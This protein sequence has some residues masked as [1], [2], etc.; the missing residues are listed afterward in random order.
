MMWETSALSE[1]QECIISDFKI[2]APVDVQ[3]GA[4]LAFCV[5]LRHDAERQSE[6]PASSMA[7]SN[8]CAFVYVFLS[9]RG[10]RKLIASA[11]L[12]A[13][14]ASC[15]AYSSV[16]LASCLSNNHD[17]DLANLLYHQLGR[18][19]YDYLRAFRVISEVHENRGGVSLRAI[20]ADDKGSESHR[21][22]VCIL[23]LD[24]ILQFAIAHK[25][26]DSQYGPCRLPVSIQRMCILGQSR[27]PLRGE[28]GFDVWMCA[29]ERGDSVILEVGSEHIRLK[30]LQIKPRSDSCFLSDASKIELVAVPTPDR[31]S[32]Q[33]GHLSPALRVDEK[34]H[35]LSADV[36]E[37]RDQIQRC[38]AYPGH[39]LLVST[40]PGFSGFVRSLHRE[41][42]YEQVRGIHVLDASVGNER[43]PDA[44]I[45]RA[46]NF[47][48]ENGEVSCL[49]VRM[50]DA[51]GGPAL[52]GEELRPAH[53]CTFLS[54]HGCFY[55]R[56]PEHQE[57]F[58]IWKAIGRPHGTSN[59]KPSSTISVA[60]TFASLNF[61]DVMIGLGKLDQHEAIKGYGHDGGGFGLDFAGHYLLPQDA[62]G[63]GSSLR[64]T[65]VI[66]LG[67]NCMSSELH[68][69]PEYL[70]W[71]LDDEADLE[72]Y[73]TVPCAYAS[74]YYA[75]CVRGRLQP[76]CTVLVHCGTGG[77]GLAALHICR[78]RLSAPESQLFVTC[79]S[80]AKRNYLA[81]T[82]GIPIANI[83]DSRSC[84]F[85]E[86]IMERTNGKGVN[87][88]LNSLTGELLKATVSC[89]SFGGVLLELGK[90]DLEPSVMQQLR[91]GDKAIMMIDLDQIMAHKDSFEEVRRELSDG[92]G[93]GEVVPLER[94]VF[95]APA[96]TNKAFECMSSSERIGKVVLQ[97]SHNTLRAEVP[98]MA[99]TMPA[100][101]DAKADAIVI[102]GGLGGFGL[103]LA[104]WIASHFG[105]SCRIIL[106]GRRSPC[107]SE[108]TSALHH[109][110]E[111][112]GADVEVRAG[113]FSQYSEISS[114]LE[115]LREGS[116]PARLLGVFNAAASTEDVA[117]D[118]MSS[119]AWQAPFASKVE[120]TLNL[121]RAVD[122]PSFQ[123]IC[124]SLR[125]FVC[126]SSV[127]AGLG[128]AYQT[129]Y[130]CANAAMERFVLDRNALGK[131][132]L[133]I[134]LGLIPHVGLAMSVHNAA[135][136]DHLRPISLLSALTQLE[137]LVASNAQ[138]L[139]A[140]Y[141]VG[142][143]TQVRRQL[144]LGN[145][146]TCERARA[147]LLRT[148]CNH[149]DCL[150]PDEELLNMPLGQMPCDSLEMAQILNAV[151]A[152][153]GSEWISAQNIAELTP[154]VLAENIVQTDAA[155][156]PGA[157]VHGLSPNK[158][159]LATT[160]LCALR[161]EQKPSTAHVVPRK[162]LMFMSCGCQ[163]GHSRDDGCQT[164]RGCYDTIPFIRQAAHCAS[165]NSHSCPC[166]L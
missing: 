149:L 94:T 71:E 131:S 30:G 132:G 70:C 140:M 60:V 46:H 32:L 121:A 4:N 108:H 6:V 109:L 59:E 61:R 81:S 136:A 7:S 126:F 65:K 95:Q 21:R 11:S 111:H 28:A 134:R 120:V 63:Q 143:S 38:L 84:G 125:H 159:D 12:T 156:H 152:K 129:N 47:F 10:S 98:N 18:H 67:H 158:V 112:Q 78:R 74:A 82:M 162:F 53:P 54:P 26:G 48:A 57:S 124:S 5:E 36:D 25:I 50:D 42:G 117:F 41:S 92:L 17:Q 161:F 122:D 62:D 87:I 75:L 154:L 115:H 148:I 35:Y 39:I 150:V 88:A 86:M 146:R 69:Q 34:A 107:T 23:A 99:A 153:V 22:K 1:K 128:N 165:Q 138:G 77:V 116:K 55:A 64:P 45:H 3:E 29:A 49:F 147:D 16:P 145:Q 44:L 127:V 105:S 100:R 160:K 8:V 90:Q 20:H 139:Y 80:N 103:C 97:I 79:G 164:R 144:M 93:N 106:C 76:D 15:F 91:L 142:V 2:R 137:R 119:A 85:S 102:V 56:S 27:L 31:F 51:D 110:R 37:W 157:P 9:S 43:L 52:L 68:E 96:D 66:G 104:Q 72:A 58:G 135:D 118:R 33:L 163:H 155:L 83:G 40:T 24:G 14:I 101:E 13:Q 89:L 133:C 130:A 141:G 166:S 151:R 123:D 114:L 73:S 19:G 113:D